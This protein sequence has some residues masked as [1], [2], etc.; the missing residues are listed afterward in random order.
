MTFSRDYI[1]TDRF[2]I[3]D[4]R[5]TCGTYLAALGIPQFD[6]SR[7]LNHTDRGVTATYNRYTYDAEKRKALLKWARRLQNILDEKVT[8]KVVNIR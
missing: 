5:R 3:H 4:L 7:V 1:D 2:S 6:I 8:D